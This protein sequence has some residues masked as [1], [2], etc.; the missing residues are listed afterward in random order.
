LVGKKSKGSDGVFIDQYRTNLWRFAGPEGAP[1]I[2]DPAC[3]RLALG[4][5]DDLLLR[6]FH[7]D[8]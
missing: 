4:R 6:S 3:V 7:L 5:T 8:G 2:G 1:L